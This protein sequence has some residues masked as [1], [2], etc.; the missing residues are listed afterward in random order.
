MFQNPH[1]AH[2]KT[3]HHQPAL[4]RCTGPTRVKNLILVAVVWPGFLLFTVPVARIINYF[5]LTSKCL[6]YLSYINGPSS[7]VM[8][9]AAAARLPPCICVSPSMNALSRQ[10]VSQ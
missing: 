6:R 4:R 10:S 7:Y 3:Q 9:T 8:Q 1:S 5:Q 2:E